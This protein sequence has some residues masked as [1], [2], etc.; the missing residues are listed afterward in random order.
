[1]HPVFCVRTDGGREGF[2]ASGRGTHAAFAP[3][4]PLKEPTMHRSRIASPVRFSFLGALSLTAL[5]GAASAARADVPPPD[6]EGC[7]MAAL[8]DACVLDVDRSSGV[9][10]GVCGKSTCPRS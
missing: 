4:V 5:L 3:P 9:K 1:M 2:T 8:G 7:R 6:T 10:K